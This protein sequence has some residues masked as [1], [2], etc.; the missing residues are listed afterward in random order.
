MHFLV[1]RAP[2]PIYFRQLMCVTV[3]F[4]CFN[5]RALRDIGCL[6]ISSV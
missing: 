2:P 3:Y 1:W 6:L 5:C 4:I